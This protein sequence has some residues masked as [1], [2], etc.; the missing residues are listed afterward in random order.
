MKQFIIA[1]IGISESINYL[2]PYRGEVYAKW[3][4]VSPEDQAASFWVATFGAAFDD[5]ESEPD[6]LIN[7]VN[8]EGVIFDRVLSFD[9]LFLIGN[10]FFWDAAA[11]V[12]YVRMF[13]DDGWYEIQSGYTAGQ[14]IGV[15]DSADVRQNGLVDSTI[16]GLVYEPILR[17]GSLDTSLSV[18]NW[19]TNQMVFSNFNVNLSNYDGRFDGIRKDVLNQR[20]D[21]LIADIEDDKDLELSDFHTIRTGVISEVSFPEQTTVLMTAEDPR[22]AWD[23][24]APSEVFFGTGNPDID[25]KIIPLAIGVCRQVPGVRLNPTAPDNDAIFQLSSVYFGPMQSVGNVYEERSPGIYTLIPPGSYTV[26]LAAGTIEFVNQ[27]QGGQVYADV[28]GIRVLESI[29]GGSSDPAYANS[30]IALTVWIINTYAGLPFSSSF[31]DIESF[32]KANNYIKLP[33]SGR[34]IKIGGEKIAEILDDLMLP[35]GATIYSEDGRFTCRRISLYGD[36]EIIRV[37]PEELVTPP[38]IE[39]SN[40]TYMTRLSYYYNL[41]NAK[42]EI[43]KTI[44][45][46]YKEAELLLQS[47]AVVKSEVRSPINDAVKANAVAT[48]RYER[49]AF[50]KTALSMQSVPPVTFRLYDPVQFQYAMNGRNQAPDLLYRVVEVDP[51]S[52]TYKLMQYE[53]TVDANSVNNLFHRIQGD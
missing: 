48:E 42:E 29:L 15:I 8:F 12:L 46:T 6:T 13:E 38:A 9:E 19:E 34:Y 20:M 21:L 11:L 26:N 44:S 37:D 36:E 5:V 45:L 51:V 18:D 35:C 3:Y 10:S 27:Y 41:S 28:E 43:S 53:E 22:K 16:G 30:P 2:A 32:Q 4:Y 7:S 17:R 49:F 25:D 47:R 33:G 39:Y 14:A 50:I 24:I 40:D 1:Q 23:G 52:R 31:Y